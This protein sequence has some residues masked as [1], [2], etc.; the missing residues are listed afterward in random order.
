MGLLPIVK[1]FQLQSDT[2]K[3]SFINI[4]DIVNSIQANSIVIEK[5]LIEIAEY[6]KQSIKKMPKYLITEDYPDSYSPKDFFKKYIKTILAPVYHDR[7]NEIEKKT[8]IQFMKLWSYNAEK[9][10]K[11]ENIELNPNYYFYGHNKNDKFLTGFSTKV[12][13]VY[14]SAFLR[15]LHGIKESVP[16]SFYLEY[17]LA[18]L[19]VD[20][21]FWRIDSKRMPKY[22]PKLAETK[23]T[24]TAKK[25]IALIQFE[26]PIKTLTK[27]KENN[28]VI[29][30]ASGAIC[31]E[32]GWSES[33]LHSFSLI[34][35][36]Y[37]V[38]GKDL[39]TPEEISKEILWNPQTIIIPTSANKPL[40]F[41][42]NH[43]H[44]D[45]HSDPIQIKDLIIFPLITR[46][47]DLTISFWQYFKDK[48]Q[49]LNIIDALRNDLVIKIE[50]NHWSYIDKDNNEIIIFED[51]LEGLQER[52]EF[53]MPIPH[54]Q[55]V[56][57]DEVFLN[58]ILKDNNLR[59]GHLLKTTFRDKSYSY[60][61]I[62]T[63]NNYELLNISSIII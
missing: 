28:F 20:F 56:F 43:P 32:T 13:E 22:W 25:D 37:K 9:I 33:P 42:E 49:S 6:T 47:R 26:I 40:N 23:T 48:N 18:T 53:E 14:R 29:L 31:P 15:V 63:V 59:L 54:G 3:I 44:F 2:K 5:I 39:P 51:W 55:Q 60:D 19:P 46:N 58:S 30:G 41:L 52:Y 17:S 34:G 7:A 62:K 50:Q 21:S 1:A 36:G 16:P 27:H 4:D 11:N 12:S 35:F 45:I 10:A 61:E 24:D 8:R 38:V 57:I